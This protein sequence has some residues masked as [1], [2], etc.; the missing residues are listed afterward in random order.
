MW[1]DGVVNFTKR[2]FGRGELSFW[3]FSAKT[4]VVGDGRGREG[5]K[6]AKLLKNINSGLGVEMM[7]AF[8][9]EEGVK[10]VYSVG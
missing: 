4:S 3:W 2:Y 6:E 1:P 5:A 9:G 7:V 8:D 10:M